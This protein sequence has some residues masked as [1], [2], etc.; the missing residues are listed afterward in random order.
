MLQ[1]L[2]VKNLALMEET[3]V[4]FGRGC[5]RHGHARRRLQY[6]NVPGGLCTG[7]SLP[8]HTDISLLTAPA[9]RR[10]RPGS[11]WKKW[12]PPQAAHSR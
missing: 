12:V 2:H 9:T 8:Q 3:E 7:E 10:R 11:C 6:Q 1:S 5:G 4:E